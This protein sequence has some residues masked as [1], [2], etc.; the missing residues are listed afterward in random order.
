VF[1]PGYTSHSLTANAIINSFLQKGIAVIPSP[2]TYQVS[3][4][5]V[6]DVVMGHVQAM[7]KGIGG[8][9]YLWAEPMFPMSVFL[10]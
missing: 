9:R 10:E 2:G 5:Y 4:A 7:E 8:E 6:D 1:G 3:F